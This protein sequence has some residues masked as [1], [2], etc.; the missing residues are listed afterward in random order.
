VAVVGAEIAICGSGTEMVGGSG[1]G[2]GGG[3]GDPMTGHSQRS[4]HP[5]CCEA[6]TRHLRR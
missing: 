4:R 1:D 2:G 3:G 5:Q 6:V